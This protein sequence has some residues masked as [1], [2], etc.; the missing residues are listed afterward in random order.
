MPG[1]IRVRL[2][3][4]AEVDLTEIDAYGVEQFGEEIA[5]AYTR[6][7]YQ[8]FDLLRRHPLAGQEEADLGKGIR[9]FTHRNHRIFYRVDDDLV[10]IVRIIHHARDMKRD[11]LG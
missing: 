2:T 3:P 6:R 9:R 4:A 10:L 1:K 5:D 8:V 11:L 7:I